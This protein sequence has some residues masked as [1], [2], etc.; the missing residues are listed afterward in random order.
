MESN[1]KK[2]KKSTY[3]KL[4]SAIALALAVVFVFGFWPL[5][6]SPEV[7]AETGTSQFEVKNDPMYIDVLREYINIKNDD[8]DFGSARFIIQDTLDQKNEYIAF[9]ADYTLPAPTDPDNHQLIDKADVSTASAL[10]AALASPSYGAKLSL[11]QFNALF[12][13]NLSNNAERS[14]IISCFIWATQEGETSTDPADWHTLTEL[15]DALAKPGGTD[16]VPVYKIIAKGLQDMASAY[17]PSTTVSEGISGISAS[18]DE[19]TGKFEFSRIGYEGGAPPL[20]A[21]TVTGSEAVYINDTKYTTLTKQSVGPKDIIYIYGDDVEIFIEQTSP[22]VL[23]NGSIEGNLFKNLKNATYQNLLTGY[24]EFGTIGYSIKGSKGASSFGITVPLKKDYSIQT[25]ENPAFEP[26]S[27]SVEGLDESGSRIRSSSDVGYFRDTISVTP[28]N[29]ALTDDFSFTHQGVVPGIYFYSVTENL[30]QTPSTPG[31]SSVLTNTIWV[32]VIVYSADSIEIFYSKNS[33]MPPINSDRW[34]ASTNTNYEET[35]TFHNQFAVP[36]HRESITYFSDNKVEKTLKGAFVGNRTFYVTLTRVESNSPSANATTGDD[37]FS[38]TLNL[39]MTKDGSI[40]NYFYSNLNLEDGTYYY[41]IKE[42]PTTDSLWIYD[43][44]VYIA[45]VTVSSTDPKQSVKLT[46]YANEAD[47]SSGTDVT[48]TGITFGNHYIGADVTIG[49][50]EDKIVKAVFG[51]FSE[52][53]D[54]RFTIQEVDKTTGVPIGEVLLT[55]LPIKGVL[56]NPTPISFTISDISVDT[57]YYVISEINDAPENWTYDTKKIIVRVVVETGTAVDGHPGEYYK[58]V[59]YDYPCDETL[60]PF[61]NNDIYKGPKESIFN[62]YYTSASKPVTFTKS[63]LGSTNPGFPSKTFKFD[64]EEVDENGT[65]LGVSSAFLP[66]DEIKYRVVSRIYYPNNSSIDV[67]FTLNKLVEGIYYFKITEVDESE[68]GDGWKYDTEEL[69]LKLNVTKKTDGT[70]EPNVTVFEIGDSKK[71]ANFENSYY[72]AVASLSFAKKC[73]ATE[74]SYF[75]DGAAF[76][77]VLTLLSSGGS[78]NPA[79]MSSTAETALLNSSGSGTKTFS[80]E[81]GSNGNAIIRNVDILANLLPGTY[82]YSIT[83]KAN[84]TSGEHWNGWTHGTNNLYAKVTVTTG[85][86]LVEWW[87]GSAWV[88]ENSLGTDDSRRTIEN[89][90][91]PSS[92]GHGVIAIGGLKTL[93]IE[94]DEPASFPK[95]A[96]KLTELKT[97]DPSDEKTGG[98]TRT[99]QESGSI[100]GEIFEFDW[101]Q[102]EINHVDT[103]S[104]V[105]YYFKIEEVQGSEAD[106]KYDPAVYVVTVRV[107]GYPTIL[108]IIEVTKYIDG[109]AAATNQYG[110]KAYPDKDS[111]TYYDME[112][113]NKYSTLPQVGKVTVKKEFV[114]AGDAPTDNREFTVVLKQGGNVMYSF[115]LNKA[116]NWTM[117]NTNVA[118]G[119]YEVEEINMP[120]WYRI[121]SISHDTVVV[122]D[123]VDLTITATNEVIP[124]PPPPAGS[125]TA[126]K[127][128]ESLDDIPTDGTE[129]TVVLKQGASVKYMF[130]LSAAN[131]WEKELSFVEPGTYDVEEVNVP[132]DY[133]KVSISHTQITVNDGDELTVTAT[134]KKTPEPTTEPTTDSPTEP[135]TPGSRVFEPATEPQTTTQAPETEPPTTTHTPETEPPTTTQKES[136]GSPETQESTTT[137]SQSTTPEEIVEESS[138]LEEEEETEELIIEEETQ[139]QTEETITEPTTEQEEIEEEYEDEEFEEVDGRIPLANGWWAEYDEEEDVWY[140]FDDEGTPLGYIKLPEGEDIEDYDVVGNLIPLWNFDGEEEEVKKPNPG[141]GDA[142]IL[143]FVSSLLAVGIGTGL[144]WHSRKRKSK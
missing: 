44:T 92:K 48:N 36:V 99:A 137:E 91:T 58:K 123:G 52:S 34:V 105:D 128:F 88:G 112:F 22:L 103:P 56:N 111:F 139:P 84:T 135:T 13:T 87:D 82:Y 41:M 27:F 28:T 20:F 35:K 50:D 23:R 8:G 80:G 95:F 96:F 102:L 25:G 121:V 66:G 18:Y 129:F 110:K 5:L 42:T 140:I 83:E 11:A 53:P 43:K 55:T 124:P 1:F 77:Y 81:S 132:S 138:W 116:N 86:P 109:T 75:P 14:M 98:I 47:T 93:E 19:T 100:N 6:Y 134:N 45:T 64:V 74:G 10:A 133:E 114:V 141:T 113:V 17:E 79:S 54:F 57:H 101:I 73:L 30:T 89:K 15:Q 16:Y 65:P 85:S 68:A 70:L 120:E 144:Y 51:A 119:T 117:E 78:D 39:A 60:A 122:T 37:A 131:N 2:S 142:G 125:V 106:W 107:W 67:N 38:R 26:F 31:W 90:Y 40:S 71:V 69:Y 94:G 127:A 29:Y 97:K 63:V 72:R 115:V 24:A 3:I 7:S 12:G 46:K 118:P 61:F 108:E 136:E 32:K 33:S 21:L 130:V 104:V 9:C 126:K 59:T 4:A 49:N 62:N 76:E 143:A